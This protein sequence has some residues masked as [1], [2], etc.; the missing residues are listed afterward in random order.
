M[1][2]VQDRDGDGKRPLEDVFEAEDQPVPEAI[3]ATLEGKTDKRK[4]PHVKGSPAFAAWVCA[5][6]GGWTGHCGKPG[7][8]V[9][10]RGLYQF[11][12]IQLGYRI[13]GNV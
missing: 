6:L 9:V 11:R 3:S 2:L 12:S 1:Q 8:V 7:P 10:L 4:N 13:A 5:R